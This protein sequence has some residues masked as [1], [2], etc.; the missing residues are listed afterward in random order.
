[1]PSARALAE[2]SGARA[3]PRFT[4]QVTLVVAADPDS[5]SGKAA[6]ARSAGVP[7]MSFATFLELAEAP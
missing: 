3:H 7:I 2:R 5:N 4:K 1:M 6:R